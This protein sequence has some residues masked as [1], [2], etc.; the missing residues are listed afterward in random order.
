MIFRNGERQPPSA[1]ELAENETKR[2]IVPD[3]VK[4]EAIFVK[5]VR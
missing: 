5:V 4:T 2:I 3:F 1:V